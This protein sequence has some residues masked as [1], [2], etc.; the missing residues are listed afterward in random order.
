[1]TNRLTIV[2]WAAAA[3]VVAIDVSSSR[4]AFFL[5][6]LGCTF[7]RQYR[8]YCAVY[9]GTIGGSVRTV[10]S[11]TLSLAPAS[12][13]SSTQ[14]AEHHSDSRVATWSRP[15]WLESENLTR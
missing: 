8:R 5:C 1:V 14:Q 9:T 6:A 12:H 7:N 15:K 4:M 13:C 10:L 2:L 11:L 3:V